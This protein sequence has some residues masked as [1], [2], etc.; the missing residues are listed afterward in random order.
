MIQ[1]TKHGFSDDVQAFGYAGDQSLIYLR[2][3]PNH[4]IQPLQRKVINDYNLSVVRPFA[5]EPVGH[6]WERNRYGM[7]TFVIGRDGLLCS[8]QVL[9]SGEIWGHDAHFLRRRDE[10]EFNFI[11]TGAVER[12]CIATLH[13]YIKAARERFGY[14]EKIWIEAG[15]VNIEGYCLASPEIFFEKFGGRI[16]EDIVVRDVVNTDVL[17][18][19][20]GFLLSFFEA[21]YEAAGMSRPEGLNGFPP[22]RN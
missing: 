4:H 13:E 5:S 6:S 16:Y 22:K 8:T 21:M 1:T 15:M 18:A 10:Y 2:V 14:S 12:D 11:P 19:I 17:A 7:N 3:W 9:K 20:D